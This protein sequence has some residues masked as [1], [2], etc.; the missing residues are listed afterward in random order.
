[1]NS[2]YYISIFRKSS[3]HTNNKTESGNAHKLILLKL[4]QVSQGIDTYTPDR[5]YLESIFFR[6]RPSWQENP[7]LYCNLVAKRTAFAWK[8]ISDNSIEL[9]KLCLYWISPIDIYKYY[10]GC[11]NENITVFKLWGGKLTF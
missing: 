8:R 10:K 2:I 6:R 3:S 9:K 1:M 11:P 7:R 4:I 5:P